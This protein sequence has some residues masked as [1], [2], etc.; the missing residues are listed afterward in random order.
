MAPLAHQ[1]REPTS[2][3]LGHGASSA[4]TFTYG[5]RFHP[6]LLQPFAIER[7][8][9]VR[10]HHAKCPPSRLV[11]SHHHALSLCGHLFLQASLQG[12]RTSTSTLPTSNLLHLFKQL[13]SAS[14]PKQDSRIVNSW[15]AHPPVPQYNLAPTYPCA[16]YPSALTH[17]RTASTQPVAAIQLTA[18]SISP[19]GLPL[20]GAA[21]PAHSLH[22]ESSA[23]STILSVVSSDDPSHAW[24]AASA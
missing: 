11:H 13:V 7:I 15:A 14:S 1:Q 10:R 21:R 8:L 22:A 4:F 24:S 2:W 16:A 19:S 17:I 3:L 5:R 23:S 12:C 18:A 6:S 20:K 9:S